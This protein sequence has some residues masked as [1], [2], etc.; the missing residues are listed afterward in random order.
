MTIASAH[1]L[2]L[3]CAIVRL[4]DSATEAVLNSVSKDM[5]KLFHSKII[6]QNEIHKGLSLKMIS[7]CC[8]F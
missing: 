7:E 5:P 2:K 4:L 8:M 6:G 1:M 3:T